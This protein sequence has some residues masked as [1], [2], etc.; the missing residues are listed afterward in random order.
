M[1]TQFPGYGFTMPLYAIVHLHCS[2]T[3]SKYPPAT[4]QD[5]RPRNKTF[6]R[7]LVP[8]I[9]IAYLIPTILMCIPFSWFIHQWIAA[10]WQGFPLWVYI[11]QLFFGRISI[12]D[13]SWLGDSTHSG[14]GGLATRDMIRLRKM[15]MARFSQCTD[16]LRTVYT[17]SIAVSTFTHLATVNLLL[18]RLL[19]P[20]LFSNLALETLGFRKVYIPPWFYSN[21]PMTTMGQSMLVFFQYDQYVGALSTIIWAWILWYRCQGPELKVELVVTQLIKVLLIILIAGPGAGFIYLIWVRDLHH[22]EN[23]NLS[24]RKVE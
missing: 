9:I 21:N 15:Q 24:G 6:L 12:S 3:A 19:F 1:L 7:T 8:S 10:L 11:L 18:L 5:I 4:S 20:Q 13:D 2:P 14:A 22:A 16:A 23:N 17:F